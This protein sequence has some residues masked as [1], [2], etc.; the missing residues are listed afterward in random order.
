MLRALHVEVCEAK[1]LKDKDAVG[2]GDPYVVLKCGGQEHKTAVKKGT[3]NP[4]WHEKFTFK[5]PGP[6]IEVEVWDKDKFSK[7]DFIGEVPPPP[8]PF[9]TSR[10]QK[11]QEPKECSV[12]CCNGG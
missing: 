2:K 9:P 8:L 12:D 4:V 3:N 6:V 10:E 5:Q 7:D 1:E 11:Q